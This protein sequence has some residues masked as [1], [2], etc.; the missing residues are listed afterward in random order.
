MVLIVEGE[1]STQAGWIMGFPTVGVPGYSTWDRTDPYRHIQHLVENSEQVVVVA[2][3]DRDGRRMSRAIAVTSL[4]RDRADRT[5]LVWGDQ[6]APDCADLRDVLV[7]HG[8]EEGACLII[9]ALGSAHLLA[10]IA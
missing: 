5:T 2:D 7:A 8:P 1:S 4:L 3:P 10:G 6:I 9:Q